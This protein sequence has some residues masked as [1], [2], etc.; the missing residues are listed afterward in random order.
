MIDI[1][2]L[3]FLFHIIAL[4]IRHG[5]RVKN[6]VFPRVFLVLWLVSM[7]FARWSLEDEILD[8]SRFQRYFLINKFGN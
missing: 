7:R 6:V 4:K 2:N 3:N 5:K 8:L 1:R